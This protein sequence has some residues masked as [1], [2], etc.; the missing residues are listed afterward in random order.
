MFVDRKKIIYTNLKSGATIN[1]PI[2]MDFTPIDNS[3]LVEDKFVNDEIEKAINP[4]VDYK[5]IIFK[6]SGKPGDPQWKEIN[7][8][9]INLNF[10][11]PD[12]LTYSNTYNVL[13]FTTDDLFCNSPRL[14]NSFLRLTFYDSPNVSNNNVLGFM[15][16]YSQVGKDQKNIYGFVLPSNESPISYTLG[17]PVLAPDT[18]HEG[19]NIYWYKDLV[20]NAPDKEYTIYVDAVYN[21]ATNGQ[22]IAMYA[23]PTP[24]PANIQMATVNAT[25]GPYYMKIVFRKDIFGIYRYTYESN[26]PNQDIQYGGGINLSPVIGIPTI[27]FWQIAP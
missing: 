12:H 8:F 15:D 2:Q 18:V 6:P 24:D 5:K 19:Y 7:K 4:I 3:E 11:K 21:N 17:N 14:I 20:D 10:F 27:S 25:D 13:N 16:I 1:I 22:S 23:T 26:N 9:Q